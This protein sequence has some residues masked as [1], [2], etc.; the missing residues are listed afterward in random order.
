MAFTKPVLE[1]KNPGI[2]PNQALKDSGWLP[3]VSP[4]PDIFNYQW[5]TSNEAIR[6]L[7]KFA[8]DSRD[9]NGQQALQ[10]HIDDLKPHYAEI[11]GQKVKYGFKTNAA[12]NGLI[13][14]Y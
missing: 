14:V 1:W 2:E 4:A 11:D 12:K 10:D 5:H 13:F 6:E 7:Q 3:A 8:V 9:G